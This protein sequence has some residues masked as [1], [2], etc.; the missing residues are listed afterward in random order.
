MGMFR[1][2][3]YAVESGLPEKS[4]G[5]IGSHTFGDL[6]SLML[7]GA[8]RGQGKGSALMRIRNFAIA[9]AALALG[10]VGA[11]PVWASSAGTGSPADQPLANAPIAGAPAGASKLTPN[12]T[13]PQEVIGC[14]LAVEPPYRVN[15]V[16]TLWGDAATGECTTP[17]PT[18]CE[19][20]VDLQYW[21]PNYLGPGAGAWVNG[22]EKVTGQ[23]KCVGLSK[24]VSYPCIVVEH[25]L[26]RTY[27]TLTEEGNAAFTVNYSLYQEFWC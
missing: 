7:H 16:K 23:S 15:G 19:I 2:S 9:A 8:S 18:S 11:P 26:W 17:P 1:P 13:K 4:T 25:R 3:E 27:A 10:T 6:P 22:A 24:P 21:N 14:G 20:T 12:A 5:R